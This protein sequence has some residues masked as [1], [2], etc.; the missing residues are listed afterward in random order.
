M[1]DRMTITDGNIEQLT[2]GDRLGFLQSLLSIKCHR[3]SVTNE[4]FSIAHGDERWG[5]L[6]SSDFSDGSL[7]VLELHQSRIETFEGN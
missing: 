5:E 7:Q 2:R 6:L 4:A 3:F 1:K